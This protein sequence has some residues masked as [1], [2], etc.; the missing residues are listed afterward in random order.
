MPPVRTHSDGLF[1]LTRDEQGYLPTADDLLPP[2]YRHT[3]RLKT[4]REEH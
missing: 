4:Y 3:Q 1:T 2:L